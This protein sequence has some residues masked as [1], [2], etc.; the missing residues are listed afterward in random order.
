M[1]LDTIDLNILSTLARDCRTSYSRIGSQIGLTSKSVK[2]RVKNMLRSGVIEKFVVRVNPAAFGYRTAIVLIRTSNGITKDDVIQR[3]KEFGDLAYHAHHVGSTS[4][5]ALII[6][7]PLD[8]KIIR[9][10]NDRLKPATVVRTSVAELSVPSTDLSDTD[11][12]IIKCLL[13]SG[14]RIEISD[15]AKEVGIS[16][17][18]TTRRL[19]RMKE[20][21]LL[22]F[23]LQCSP[24]TMIGYIQ[25]A[26]PIIVAKTHYRSVLER[27]YL[28]FQTNILYSPSVIEPENQLTFILFGENVFVVDYVLAK[29]NSFA[30]VKSADAYILT[31]LQYYDNWIMKE[32]NK[33]LLLRPV[34]HS[35]R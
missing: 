6:K 24:T 7:K 5:A 15:I 4:V 2:A 31:K 9:S 32:I 16:E 33:R 29:V 28:E 14:A 25:F 8:E 3:I 30:G 35:S 13:L 22:D 17:K 27:M 23:S 19:D 11:L 10:L 20:G 21:R 12:R 1:I 18:T 34:L 26:I